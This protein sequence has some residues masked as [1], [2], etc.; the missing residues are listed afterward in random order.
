VNLTDYSNV[1]VEVKRMASGGFG[2]VY[3]GPC[4][5]HGGR[6]IALK[7]LRP[8]VLARS[9]RAADLFVREGLTWVGL[10]P[11]PNLLLTEGVTTINDQP[12]LILDYAQR[13]SLRDLLIAARKQGIW[14]PPI[15][16]LEWAQHIAAGLV[17]LHTPDPAFLRPQPIVHRD[18]KPEN[19][20]LIEQ[21]YAQITDFGLA[22][23]VADGL[24]AE[25]THVGEWGASDISAGATGSTHTQFYQTARGTALG[26]LAYMAPEQWLDASAA[27]PPADMY[28]F[29]LI[30][31]ELLAGRHPLLDL[32][33]PYSEQAWREA[34]F[35]G[36]PRPLASLAAQHAEKPSA[37]TLALLTQA[38]ERYQTCLRKQ[39]EA[40]STA[41]EA[42][43]RLQEAAR[44]L[45]GQRPYTPSEIWP[46]TV[47]HEWG[48]WHTWAV[49]Y[50]TFGL[51]EEALARNDRALALAPTN[52]TVLTSR[53]NIL[54]AL[55]RPEEALA[56]SDQALAAL[57]SADAT[58]K[59]TQW[60]KVIWNNRGTHLN[61]LGRYAEAEA[62]YAQGLTLV[63]DAAEVW[64]N[65]A[66]N[67]L[68]WGK[69]EAQAEHLEVART[70]WRTGVT[71]AEQA[72]TLN[73]NNSLF[74]RLLSVLRD[75]LRRVG[76][77]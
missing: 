49:T 16:A 40:R 53:G 6:W 19:I 47:E 3:F 33:Q 37:D 15:L 67:Q 70:H 72:V 62:T 34:H 2:Q 24:G 38:E 56:V 46:H 39:P 27:G 26:T 76:N 31:G 28:A 20:L 21:G 57:P 55:G 51:Y 63:P 5:L 12:F 30:L 22:K 58:P 52:P 13:G 11:H 59:D 69:A 68:D 73:S 71:Y 23:V 74:H 42:L 9:R 8:D 65:R 36:Q 25:M 29:G 44:R 54:E 41:G 17:T 48:K 77:Q 35:S 60:R 50:E 66:R 75:M 1:D 61:A 18:L 32:V 4:R 14:M 45:L 10:W 7:T 43:A 64:H